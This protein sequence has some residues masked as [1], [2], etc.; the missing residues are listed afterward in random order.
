MLVFHLILLNQ[1]PN[2]V[3]YIESLPLKNVTHLANIQMIKLFPKK[4]SKLFSLANKQQYKKQT[5]QASPRS[6]GS[7]TT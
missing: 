3:D 7:P 2:L 4:S 1:A 6:P 5:T